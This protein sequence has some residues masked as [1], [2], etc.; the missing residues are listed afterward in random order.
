M[1]YESWRVS[2]SADGETCVLSVKPKNP[3]FVDG[4]IDIEAGDG[5]CR[6]VGSGVDELSSLFGEKMRPR[7]LLDRLA[8]CG[9]RLSPND[10]DAERV[11]V[12]RK[13]ERLE[14]EFCKDVAL[15]APSFAVTS[16]RWNRDVGAEDA[17]ARFAEVVDYDLIS[18]EDMDK[19]FRR[20]RDGTV[21]TLLRKTKGVTVVDARHK[22]G[23]LSR[24]ARVH[25]ED[26]RERTEPQ[27]RAMK[28]STRRSSR[29]VPPHRAH[30]C[31]RD[32]N[33]RAT[34]GRGAPRVH[35]RGDDV[36]FPHA[37]SL[38]DERSARRVV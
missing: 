15:M 23:E 33:L 7:A 13:D 30:A 22:H 10:A 21:K 8:A 34:H 38:S 32:G 12:T 4:G 37:H 36:T 20:E 25:M 3:R 28:V 19:I 6:L 35:R 14:L 2:P 31:R 17:L 24:S 9:A 1:P 18:H 5:W 26:G 27:L 29:R 16:C 11:G